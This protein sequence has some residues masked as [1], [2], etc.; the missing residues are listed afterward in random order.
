MGPQNGIMGNDGGYGLNLPDTAMDEANAELADARKKARFSRTGEFQ[1]LKSKLEERMEYYKR[2][3]P[4]SNG[5]SIALMDMP[6]DERGWRCLAADCIITEFRA[7][8]AAYEQAAQMV[9][10]EQSKR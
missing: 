3:M 7:V 2:F 10:D 5:T 8:I 1:E 9:K 4:G 6:N